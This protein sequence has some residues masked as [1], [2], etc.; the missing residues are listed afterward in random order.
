MTDIRTS[1]EIAQADKDFEAFEKLSKQEQ[2]DYLEREVNKAKGID[3]QQPSNA[4]AA[5]QRVKL[6]FLAGQKLFSLN[7]ISGAVIECNDDLIRVGQDWYVE[8]KP[9]L[10]Y[11]PAFNIKNAIFRLNTFIERNQKP[12]ETADA[13]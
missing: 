12:K 4:K 2:S 13:S 3:N 6:K 9:D 10:L 5:P 11:C 7:K 8:I 1:A